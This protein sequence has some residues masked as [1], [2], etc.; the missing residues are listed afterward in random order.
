MQ[1]WEVDVFVEE[2]DKRRVSTVTIDAKT[3]DEA[4]RRAKSE[5][6]RALAFLSP[7]AKVIGAKARRKS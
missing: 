1:Q 7:F 2:D 6:S 3:E 5:I 4:V